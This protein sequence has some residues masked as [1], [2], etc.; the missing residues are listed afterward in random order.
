ML[1]FV[2]GEYIILG[3]LAD[4]ISIRVYSRVILLQSYTTLQNGEII[5]EN[6]IRNNNIWKYILTKECLICNSFHHDS[7]VSPSY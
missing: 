5:S 6:Q 1:A 2:M 4:A 7:K 3:I